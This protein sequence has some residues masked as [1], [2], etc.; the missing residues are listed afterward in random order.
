[1][2]SNQAISAVA[3][4]RPLYSDSVLDWDRP[5]C[6]VEDPLMRA[7]VRGLESSRVGF[8]SS[9]SRSG[10]GIQELRIQEFGAAVSDAG[11]TSTQPTHRRKVR[12][13]H[14]HQNLQKT[15]GIKTQ[16]FIDQIRR[17]FRYIGVI[18]GRGSFGFSIA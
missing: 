18:Q 2:D 1:M 9:E 12:R 11:Q 8:E 7:R 17:V 14:H 4:A 16:V 13:H 6:L 3:F 10:R 15:T 5:F